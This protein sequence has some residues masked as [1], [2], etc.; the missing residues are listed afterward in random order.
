[1]AMVISGRA[2]SVITALVCII[3]LGAVLVA[4]STKGWFVPQKYHGEQ[5]AARIQARIIIILSYT[6]FDNMYII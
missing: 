6:L 5:V 2:K 3:L 1:M 4:G